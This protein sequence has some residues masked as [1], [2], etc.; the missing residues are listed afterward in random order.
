MQAVYL[1]L[2]V[3]FGLAGLAASIYLIIE[4]FKDEIWK[5]IVGLLCGLYLL[6]WALVEFEHEHKWLIVVVA[7]GG[8]A[9]AYGFAALAGFA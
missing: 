8:N 5:G 4:A 9:I 7:F 3:I 1:I 6:Y 2:A